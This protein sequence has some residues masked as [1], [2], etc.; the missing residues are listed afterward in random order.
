MILLSGDWHPLNDWVL[1]QDA[2]VVAF[3]RLAVMFLCTVNGAIMASL[4]LRH[5][6]GNMPGLAAVG[7]VG[8]MAAIAG[9]SARQLGALDLYPDTALM[10]VALV[11]VLASLLG[12]VRIG[13]FRKQ[14][15]QRWSVEDYDGFNVPY[16]C[17]VARDN[18]IALPKN[19]RRAEVVEVLIKNKTGPTRSPT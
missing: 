12:R 19:P 8:I 7:M 16:L 3:I 13:L 2:D 14:H 15:H 6:V 17:R 11:L 10:L 5:R 1:L 4:Y 18:G 9:A